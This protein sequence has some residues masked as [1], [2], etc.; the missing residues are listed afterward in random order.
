[1]R[2][3]RFALLSFVLLFLLI[4]GISL[5]FPSHVRISRAVDIH[6]PAS[7]IHAQLSQPDQW[8]N[9]FPG[10]DTLELVID[11]GKEIGIRTPN[12]NALLLK[13]VESLQVTATGK[14]G[15]AIQSSMGWNI[16]G[17]AAASHRTVQ[18]YMD[19]EFDWY[20]WEKF[21]SLLLEPRYGPLMER[22]LQ[23]LKNYCEQQ[24]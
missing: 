18:W 20:P 17:D 8:R 6:A 3:L 9:W 4:T 14:L 21:A 7:L 11:E 16:M 5:F 13:D 23:Q 12:G 2:I 24:P 19:F 22:G 15:A 10:I 1:M